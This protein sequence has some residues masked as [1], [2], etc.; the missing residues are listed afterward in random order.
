MP[1][2]SCPKIRIGDSQAFICIIVVNISIYN[3]LSV[4]GYCF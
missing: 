3:D 2:S 4:F 1:G